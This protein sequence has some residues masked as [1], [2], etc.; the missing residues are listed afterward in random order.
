MKKFFFA[1]LTALCLLSCQNSRQDAAEPQALTVILPSNP[2]TLNTVSAVDAYASTI[3]D[4]LSDPLIEID[5]DLNIIPCVA[6]SWKWTETRENGRTLYV[7]TFSL[8]DDVY[9][10]DGVRMTAHD[11]VYTYS[12]ITNIQSKAMN[13]SVKFKGLVEWAR[14][15]DDFTFS[16]AYNRR[17]A[18]AL[19]SWVDM[20]ALP[21]HLYQNLSWE[22]FHASPYNRTPVGNGPFRIQAWETSKRIVLV[23]NTNYWRKAPGMKKIVY[24]II[25]DD[26]VALIAFRKGELDYYGFTPEQFLLEARKPALSNDYT[27]LTYSVFHTGQ[28]AW[29]CAPGSLFSDHRVRLAMTH[30]LDRQG[31]SET[32]YHGLATVITGP[33]YI[34]SWAYDKSI[35]PWPFDLDKARSLLED[36]G[37]KDTDNDG[38]LDKDGQPFRFEVLM[39]SGSP[40]LEAVLLNLKENLFRIGVEC[41]LRP[42]EWGAL[43]TRLRNREFD[44]LVFGW[45]LDYDPD[46]YDIFHSDSITNGLNYGSFRNPDLDR[47][48]EQDRMTLNT[49]ARKILQYQM[50]RILHEQQAYTHLFSQKAIVALRKD[51]KGWEIG[52]NGLFRHYPGFDGLYRETGSPTNQ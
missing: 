7:L 30:A 40:E 26:N 11:W 31:L 20:Y 47:L 3:H 39:G 17:F 34:N 1:G 5:K 32:L 13:K 14:A 42:L 22:E 12:T 24:K 8:R 21:R 45:S 19:M 33:N 6:R 50:H 9:W 15:D 23:E 43:S 29:N 38:I 49:S 25:T 27:I 10:H 44:A 4:R 52:A 28:I 18:P 16:L 35:K 37:W 36:A 48:I 46:L 2:N 51:L 41:E